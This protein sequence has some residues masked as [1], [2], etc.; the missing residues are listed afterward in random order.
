MDIE[1]ARCAH[2]RA[3]AKTVLRRIAGRG[4]PAAAPVQRPHAAA[5]LP[6]HAKGKRRPARRQRRLQRHATTSPGARAPAYSMARLII[7]GAEKC[8]EETDRSLVELM[9][10]V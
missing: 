10:G 8:F 5:L 6:L 9:V 3:R 1:P 4:G 7:L 2:T